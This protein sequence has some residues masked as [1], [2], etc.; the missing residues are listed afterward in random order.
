MTISVKAPGSCGELAQGTIDGQPFLITCPIDWYA[1]ARAVNISGQAD[2]LK[3]NKA[4]K[5]TLQYIGV[6]DKV[7]IQIMSD[8]PVGKGMA[9]SSADISAACQATALCFG[10][11][12]SADEIADIALSI[13]PTDGIF[14]PGIMM[15][16][17]IS[18]K[19]RIPLGQ[20]PELFISIFDAGGEVDTLAFNQRRDLVKL[21][22]Q[23]ENE[24]RTAV[25]LIRKGLA[26]GNAHRIGEGATISSLSNQSILY[27]PSLASFLKEFPHFGAVGVNVAHS[28]TVIGVLFPPTQT[29]NM[30]DFAQKMEYLCPGIRHV[31]NVRLISGGL[32]WKAGEKSELP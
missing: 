31:R 1:E 9:S 14:Y 17:H 32:Q 30:F 7:E 28:G 25:D 10:R 13:E 24:I 26:E 6:T 15:F 16:D 8:I 29:V 18:G 4:A 5:A 2:K 20:P 27:K 11:E 23:K 19:L 12:L 3:T 22:R 21:N